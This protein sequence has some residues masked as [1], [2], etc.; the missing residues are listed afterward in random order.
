MGANIED[1]LFR[2]LRCNNILKIKGVNSPVYI[3]I[4]FLLGDS[5]VASIKTG[6]YQD[7]KATYMKINGETLGL[8]RAKCTAYQNIIE[9]AISGKKV[10]SVNPHSIKKF[11]QIC[12]EINKCI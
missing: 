7:R 5:L 12:R 10:I 6:K 9:D 8:G 2:V 11:W 3:D 1:G 4:D